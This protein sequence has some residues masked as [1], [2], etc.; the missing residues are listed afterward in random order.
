MASGAL[1]YYEL[2]M[3]Q[4]RVG[5]DGEVT[6]HQLQVTPQPLVMWGGVET[7]TSPN[8]PTM[9]ALNKG[10]VTLSWEVPSNNKAAMSYEVQRRQLLPH[11][12]HG[13]VSLG[14][15]PNLRF[16]FNLA[17][18]EIPYQYRIIPIDYGFARADEPSTILEN[19]PLGKPECGGE[20]FT[21]LHNPTYPQFVHNAMERPLDSPSKYPRTFDLLVTTTFG[22]HCHWVDAKWVY[23][24]RAFYFKHHQD[25]SCTEPVGTSCTVLNETP[26]SNEEA[27][28]DADPVDGDEETHL[29]IETLWDAE[30]YY[31][32]FPKWRLITFTDNDIEKAGKYGIQYRACAI[33]AWPSSDGAERDHRCSRWRD[34]GIHFVGVDST[35]FTNDP[36][37]GELP[38]RVYPD[39]VK[40]Y[41]ELPEG[42]WPTASE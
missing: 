19:P 41:K 37:V 36:P 24:Q 35:P 32:G 42:H 23:F 21:G 8:T 39:A 17:D 5:T 34:T 33:Q 40:S 16:A 13:F 28:V 4:K 1:Y 20:D 15:T 18:D 11:N 26:L 25:P 22:F 38:L 31:W 10:E 2:T 7:P 27:G 9:D 12:P 30:P 3:F 29:E 14:T 6:Y